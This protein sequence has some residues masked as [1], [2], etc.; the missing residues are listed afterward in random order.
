MRFF[1]ILGLGLVAMVV[2]AFAFAGRPG[3][4]GSEPRQVVLVARGMAF[5]APGGEGGPNPTL[6]LRAGEYV[7]LVLQNQDPGMRHDVVAPGLGLK[8]AAVGHGETQRR[9]FRVPRAAGSYD[10]FCSF[11]DR[12]MRGRMVVE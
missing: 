7:R 11:H 4:R 2:A 8:T 3:G 1:G 6:R 5:V 10:Y 12:L 9:L